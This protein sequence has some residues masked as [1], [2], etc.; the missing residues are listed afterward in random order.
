MDIIEAKK[1]V[2]E[3]GKRLVETG[4]IART[5]GNVSCRVSDTQ[6]VITPS[7]RAYENLTPDEIVLVNIADCSYAGDVKPTSEKKVHA[8]VYQLRPEMNFVIHTHQTYASIVGA[9]GYDIN[10]MSRQGADI[11]GPGVTVAAYGLPGTKKLNNG[12]RDALKRSPSKAIIMAH[13]G[14]VCMGA[15]YEDA[16][17][18]AE[19]LEKVSADFIRRRFVTLTG[20][21]A[22]TY[23]DLIAYF[24]RHNNGKKDDT[25][26]SFD[27]YDSSREGNTA[28][29][30]S[31]RDGSIIRVNLDSPVETT[32][33]G[34]DYTPSVDLHKAVY[35]AREDVNYIL[36]SDNENIKAMSACKKVIKPYLDDFAQLVGVSLKTAAFD[37]TS[38]LKSSKQIA[39]KLKGRNAVMIKDNGALC[40]AGDKYDAEAVEMVLNKNI[41]ARAATGVFPGTKAINKLESALMRVVYKTKYSKNRDK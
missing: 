30:V 21:V 18:V 17:R 33:G 9:V 12:V 2:I 23:A 37:P 10:S 26:A 28:V 5:W 39:K 40:V 1:F 31:K 25:L 41:M 8:S 34:T 16:F 11:I 20:A 6:F 19:E 14:A 29:L 35:T 15:D 38:V 27:Y 36:H 7:G 3:A 13:H 24:A 22:D 4:L 32:R